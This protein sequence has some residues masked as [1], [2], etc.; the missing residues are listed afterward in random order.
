V[1]FARAT[2][3]GVFN[4]T[5]WDVAVLPAWQ[6]CGIGRAMMERL[7][8]ALVEEGIANVNLFAE[9][10]VE[11]MYG[12]MGWSASP[13]GVRGMAYDKS[14]AHNIKLMER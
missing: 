2:S 12:K 4:A 5:I 1:G 3:D 9:P 8:A 11:S 10:A 6:G 13:G 7:T 14:K